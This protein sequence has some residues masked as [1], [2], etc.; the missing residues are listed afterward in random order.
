[1]HLS[2]HLG[3]VL[4]TVSD[5][6]LAEGTEGSTAT[7]YRA[8]VLFASDYYQ[9]GMQMPGRQF[10]QDEYRYGFNGMEKD[11]ELAGEGNSYTTEWRQLDTRIGRWLSTDP[12][13]NNY[14]HLSPY[15]FANC[16]PIWF[17]EIDGA[18]FDLSN[19]TENQKVKFEENLKILNESEIFRIIYNRLLTSET[20][21][22]INAGAG[23]GG[24]GSFEP[25]TNT[26]S[27]GSVPST[28]AQEM[29][30]AYQSDLKVYDKKDYSVIEAEGDI[31]MS[32]ILIQAGQMYMV[33]APGWDRS[34]HFKYLNN[35]D[36]YEPWSEDGSTDEFDTEFSKAVDLR[37]EVYMNRTEDP[38][39]S[40]VQKNSGKDAKALKRASKE[41]SSEEMVG[42]RLSNGEFYSK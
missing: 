39:P 29:F 4:V 11:D 30:H 24:S 7:G 42:P 35:D 27:I 6:K 31:A 33:G 32:V 5:R 17:Y 38:P 23:A 34:L 28:N 22:S 26:I 18:I 15:H 3:N 10:S 14:H 21:Y 9:F 1:M 20:V 12:A 37:I 8:E 16:N 19:L 25:K 36:E 40:Y 2:N 41:A 13:S